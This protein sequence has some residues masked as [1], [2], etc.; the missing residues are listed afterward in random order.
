MAIEQP[1]H[2]V[3]SEV[4][5]D[6]KKVFMAGHSN[7]C[8]ASLSMA[9]LHSDLVTGVACHAG[10]SVTPFAEG[11]IPVPTLMVH[12]MK[13]GS[14]FVYDGNIGSG[15]A[16]FASTPDQFMMIANKNGCAEDILTETLPGDE[17]KV[18]TR[19]GCLNDADVT[20]VTL[21]LGSH[22]PYLDFE[23]GQEG[24]P[25]SKPT[26]I[27]TTLLAW[28]FL[29]MIGAETTTATPGTTTAAPVA[30][31]TPPSSDAVVL[32]AYIATTMMAFCLVGML[33]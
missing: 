7:G 5:I 10:K 11:Y 16:G 26:T 23:A 28:K 17:G 8:V 32:Q 27:D 13:D 1:G 21:T 24:N 15:G 3:G 25:G 29:S 18:E 20:L 6:S 4:S 30:A 14:L 9:A 31:P 19:T 22:G 33:F 2:S 12:G